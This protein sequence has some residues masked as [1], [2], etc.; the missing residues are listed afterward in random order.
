MIYVLAGNALWKI[1]TG[2]TNPSG[3]TVHTWPRTVGQVHQYVPHY[4]EQR[5][6]PVTQQ[7]ADFAP[8]TPLVDCSFF[9]MFSLFFCYSTTHYKVP[10]GFGLSY[11]NF[12]F[13]NIR[14]LARGQPCDERQPSCVVNRSIDQYFVVSAT[15]KNT[16]NIAGKVVVEVYFSQQLASRVRFAQ[17]LL[18]FKKTNDIAAGASISVQISVAITG[19]EMWSPADKKY[20]VEASK[21]DIMVGQYVSDPKMVTHTLTVV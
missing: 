14:L 18:D 19:L 21:Y 2:N 17:M 10:F 3:R 8:A 6:R 15:V 12:T 5:T 11:T 13:S 16:G 9:L 4:L 20:V 7:Y 1:I